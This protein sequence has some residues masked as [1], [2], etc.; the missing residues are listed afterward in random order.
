[1]G[2]GI[3]ILIMS[4]FYNHRIKIG[5]KLNKMILRIYINIHFQE[6]TEE[7]MKVMKIIMTPKTK[8]HPSSSEPT[9]E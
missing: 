4:R 8:I 7:L 3:Y 5:M 2:I 1:M 6:D 9:K